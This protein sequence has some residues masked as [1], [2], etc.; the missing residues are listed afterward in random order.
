M[1]TTRG[2][3]L[4]RG[5]NALAVTA[6]MLFPTLGTW[7]YFVVASGE[8]WTQPIYGVSKIVQ[9]A[10]P[11]LWILAIQRRSLQ[12]AWPGTRGI[13]TGL[14]FGI[15]VVAFLLGT[16]FGWAKEASFLAAAPGEIRTK[17]ET[18]RVAT[19]LRFLVLALFYSLAHSA[20]EEYYWRWFVFGELRR[21]I[22]LGA[23]I[24]LS[25]VAFAAHHVI[26][27]GTFL[28]PHWYAVALASAGVGIGGAV[29]AWLYARSGSLVGPWLSHLLVDAGLMLIGYDLVWG[30]SS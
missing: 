1:A 29:W 3:E 16:Y 14:V 5:A 28:A 26:I 13:A 18:F 25:S 2:I 8:S 21:M 17:L 24:A 20:L 11:L 7:L 27:I 12:L 4:S 22:P 10:F 23:A 30:F 6:A 15:L 9:F 19:P